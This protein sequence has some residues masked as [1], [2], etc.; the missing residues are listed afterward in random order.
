MFMYIYSNL[1]QNI[2]RSNEWL[3]SMAIIKLKL[4]NLYKTTSLTSRGGDTDG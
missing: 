4:F 2:L 3:V 1:Q